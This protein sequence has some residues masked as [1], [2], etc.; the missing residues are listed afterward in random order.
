[1]LQQ[2]LL[3]VGHNHQEVRA[4]KA[5]LNPDLRLSILIPF[6]SL[7]CSLRPQQDPLWGIIVKIL[8]E[9]G[10]ANVPNPAPFILYQLFFSF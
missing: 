9:A 10:F 1:M 5:L 8:T 4:G 6:T 3:S 2:H 7:L